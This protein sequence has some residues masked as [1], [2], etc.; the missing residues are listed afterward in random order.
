MSKPRFEGEERPPIGPN[1]YLGQSEPLNLV[2][3]LA[4]VYDSPVVP[5]R[6]TVLTD[7]DGHVIPGKG[8]TVRPVS[9]REI[10]GVLDQGAF[11]AEMN[12]MD[13]DWAD[14]RALREA[15][16]DAA[17]EMRRGTRDSRNSR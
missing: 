6:P 1:T 16:R 15:R 2:Q 11:G 7:G 8:G 3:R 17:K 5:G 4:H 14:Q 9:P 13:R 10:R 12:P